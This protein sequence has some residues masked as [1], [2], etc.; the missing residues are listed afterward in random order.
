[1]ELT[2]KPTPKS[3][4]IFGAAGHIGQPLAEYVTCEG[5]DIPTSACRQKHRKAENTAEQVSRGRVLAADHEYLSSFAA[6]VKGVEGVFVI[7]SSGMW[8][9]V[10]MTNLT[11][12]LKQD[13]SAVQVI[14]LLGIFPEFNPHRRILNESGLPVTYI[15]CGASII[16][17]LWLQIQPVLLNK[18]FIWPEHRV[19]FLD[20]QDIAEVAGRLFL[21]DNAKHI[22]AFHTMNNGRNWLT[23]EEVAGILSDELGEKIVFDASYEG[24]TEFWG[25]R[26]GKKAEGLWDFFKFEQAKEEQWALNNFVEPTL[27]RKPTTVR[28]WIVEHKDALL[29]ATHPVS[30]GE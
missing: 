29:H 9:S 7:S 20:P 19:P 3:I 12:V 6:A 22:G 30:R 24:F 23:Y 8:E 25:P 18:T 1:M 13:S 14:R 15:N 26:M 4:L 5:P 11:T 21:S 28:G 10:A 2:K 27:G 17:N 16:D